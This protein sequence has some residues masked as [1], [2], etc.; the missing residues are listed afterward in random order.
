MID[1]DRAPAGPW[2]CNECRRTGNGWIDIGSHFRS[3][4][5]REYTSVAPIPAPTR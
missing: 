3:T 5:H 2:R 4:G 1:P